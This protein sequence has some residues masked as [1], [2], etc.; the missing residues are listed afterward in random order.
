MKAAFIKWEYALYLQSI[1]GIARW[2]GYRLR[3]WAFRKI[4]KLTVGEHSWI[5]RGLRLFSLGGI[6]IGEYCVVNPECWL[7]GRRGI[8][9]GNSVH[10]GVGSRILTLGHDPQDPHFGVKGAPVVIHDYAWLGAWSLVMPGVEIGEGAVVGAGSVV[11]RDVDPYTI[12]CG[13][14]ARIIGQRTRD[15]SYQVEWAPLLQ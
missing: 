12:V 7:D 9:L 6:T 11:T 5:H 3:R 1:N 14:P 2:P 13:N 4:G 10:L 8:T 15:L